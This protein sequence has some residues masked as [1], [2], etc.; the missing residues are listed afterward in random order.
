MAFK[1]S[2]KLIAA[3]KA[4]DLAAVRQLLSHG[5]EPRSRDAQAWSALHIAASSGYDEIVVALVEAGADVNAVAPT[6]EVVD[7]TTYEGTATP[8]M[9]ALRC[10]HGDTALCLIERG[11]D[12]NHKDAFSGEDALFSAVQK[13]MLA[14]V[15]RLLQDGRPTGR[16]GFQQRSAITAALA[17]NHVDVA[18][19]LL[20]KGYAPDADTL[21][22]ACR[23]GMVSLLPSLVSAGADVNAPTAK[24]SALAVA[25]SNGQ[26]AVLDWLAA[27]GA[28]LPSQTSE[29]MPGAGGA[30]HT[31]VLRWLVTH[32]ADVDAQTYYGWT[33]LTSA[34]W[35][36]HVACVELLLS[37]GANDAIEDTQGKTALDWAKEG[38][39]DEVARILT[40]PRSSPPKAGF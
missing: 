21:G 18:L 20:A 23:G 30:G 8:L 12:V 19:L 9:M 37:L 2:P 1:N 22:M 40:S 4:G 14:V 3:A 26:L 24:P 39:R 13:G 27:H 10:G 6:V 29:A 32:G 16:S 36:G 28:D 31:E 5:A 35:Q 17:G 33:A 25:A 7:R 15:E 11:A 34:A 38:K